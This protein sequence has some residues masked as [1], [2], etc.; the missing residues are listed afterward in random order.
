MER[1]G[2]PAYPF[3]LP[4]D[5]LLNLHLPGL[6]FPSSRGHAAASSPADPEPR[7]LDFEVY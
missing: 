3:S 2:L 1:G 4:F 6:T 5:L 7:P